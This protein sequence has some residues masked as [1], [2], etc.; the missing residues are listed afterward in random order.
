[1]T[2]QDFIYNAF[3]RQNPPSI[4]RLACIQLQREGVDFTNQETWEETW[5][6]IWDRAEYIVKHISKIKESRNL[7]IRLLNERTLDSL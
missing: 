5:N 6:L 3:F 1:M 7:Y 4:L 2:N